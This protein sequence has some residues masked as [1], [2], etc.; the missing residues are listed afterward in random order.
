MIKRGRLLTKARTLL[1]QKS[2]AYSAWI[3][4]TNYYAASVYALPPAIRKAQ[5]SAFSACLL[6]YPWLAK[7]KLPAVLKLLQVGNASDFPVAT[8]LSFIGL[9]IRRHGPLA[10]RNEAFS[11][12]P[13]VLPRLRR[14]VETWRKK[15]PP[16][17][18]A[19]LRDALTLFSSDDRNSA[20]ML[21]GVR[22]VLTSHSGA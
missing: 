11:D 5:M 21:A 22:K 10:V 12:L 17:V 6:G 3:Q 1:Q 13:S 15:L 14:I 8:D 7:A 16:N 18:F 20:K 19:A 2:L 4:S 9:L